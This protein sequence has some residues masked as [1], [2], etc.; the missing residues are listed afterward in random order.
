MFRGEPFAEVWFKPEGQPLALTFRIPQ[1]SFQLP[2]MGQRLT[3][4]NLLKAV[5]VAPEQLESCRKEGGQQSGHEHGLELILPLSPPA[6][7]V[8]QLVLRVRLKPPR[9]VASQEAAP[10]VD[11][12]AWEF[13]EERWKLILGLEASLDHVRMGMEGLRS[14]MEA[15]TRKT[16]PLDVKAQAISLDVVQWDKAKNRIRFAVPKMNEFIHRAIWATGS[17][18]RKKLAELFESHV[19]PRIPFPGVDG[20]MA[21]LD[22]LLK[23]R[24]TL[25][26]QATSVY[27][28]CKRLSAECQA[29]LRTLE[30]NAYARRKRR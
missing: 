20:V 26:A 16:L 30:G 1:R 24:Q 23:D 8:P 6:H 10:E 3:L 2:G 27:Q 15:S 21:Q 17:P 9:A 14:E 25:N 28:E 29:A 18:E 5:G 13:L 22:G 11:E 12:A 7:D 4:G 19:K